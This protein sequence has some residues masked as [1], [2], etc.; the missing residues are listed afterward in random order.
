MSHQN[1]TQLRPQG[2][3]PLDAP[4][5]LID[6]PGYI[7][8]IKEE[9]SWDENSRNAITVVKTDG[10]TMT[11][12]AMKKGAELTDHKAEGR[13]TVHVLKGEVE[14]TT[15]EGSSPL[16]EGQLIT[17]TKAIM[18]TVKATEKSVL[19]LTILGS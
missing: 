8:Q 14:F 17:L 13:I 2:D 3:R 11:I 5:M 15:S 6:I 12:I 18:H 19:L 10:F 7:D 16:K 4:L 9:D 1:A